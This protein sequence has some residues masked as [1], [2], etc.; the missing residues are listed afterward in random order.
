MATAWGVR[1]EGCSQTSRQE[2]LR[3]GYGSCNNDV[4]ENAAQAQAR[5][6]RCRCRPAP[7]PRVTCDLTAQVLLSHS[8]NHSL[9]HTHSP[10]W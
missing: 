4:Q 9:N 5:E 6:E 7:S 8:L 10:L 1:L 2:D 3:H